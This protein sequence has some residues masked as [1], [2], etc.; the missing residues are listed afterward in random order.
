[1]KQPIFEHG[2]TRERDWMEIHREVST[3]TLNAVMVYSFGRLMDS[4]EEGKSDS[5]AVRARNAF[6][7]ARELER[8]EIAAEKASRQ[9]KILEQLDQDLYQQRAPGKPSYW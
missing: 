2:G 8:R 7:N 9:P 4:I 1:M 5:A 3:A 6:R